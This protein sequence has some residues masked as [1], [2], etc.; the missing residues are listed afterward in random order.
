MTESKKRGWR[1][2]VF[3]C[4]ADTQAHEY[5]LKLRV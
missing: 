5:E 1:G 2:E 3:V 4:H